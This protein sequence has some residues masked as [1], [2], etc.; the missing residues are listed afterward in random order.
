MRTLPTQGKLN[1]E[2]EWA[3]DHW[4]ADET[5][6]KIV[7]QRIHQASV[8]ERRELCFNAWLDGM[9]VVNSPRSL[10]SDVESWSGKRW[11][12]DPCRGLRARIRAAWIGMTEQLRGT[13]HVR[14][15]RIEA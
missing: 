15:E 6:F 1:A 11:S 13:R 3:Y 4:R 7:A 2:S 5:V 14:G 8:T 10:C 12:R 9:L